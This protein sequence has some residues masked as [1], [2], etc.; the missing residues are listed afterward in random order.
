MLVVDMNAQFLKKAIHPIVMKCEDGL[1]IKE[2]LAG[3]SKQGDID[4]LKTTIHGHDAHNDIVAKF[5]IT[6]SFKRK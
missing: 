4:T 3:L 2:T 5:E 6:W 1:R